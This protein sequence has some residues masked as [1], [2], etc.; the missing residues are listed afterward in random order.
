MDKRRK[1][2]FDL[3]AHAELQYSN[4]KCNAEVLDLSETG[5]RLVVLSE[6][7]FQKGDMLR[8]QIELDGIKLLSSNKKLLNLH[9]RLVQVFKEHL[10]YD[11]QPDSPTDKAL[12][13]ELIALREQDPD[14]KI[15][16]A[17]AT[18]NKIENKT[19]NE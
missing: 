8:V 17:T 6:H 11:F 14:A 18:E 15:M 2:R 12:L 4:K 7:L 9:G 3:R 10:H 16:D 13:I 19:E 1:P 5:A